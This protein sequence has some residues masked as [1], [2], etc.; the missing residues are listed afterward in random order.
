MTDPIQLSSPQALINRARYAGKDF[1]TF[2]DDLVARVKSNFGTEYDEFVVSALGQMLIDQVAWAAETLSFYVDRQAAESY[3][4]TARTRRAASNIA[5]QLGYKPAR[6]I[7][8]T[9]DVAVNL[10]NVQ[11]VDS[12]INAGFKFQG[13]NGLVFEATQAVT[14][15]AGEGP[16]SVARSISV[17]EGK[18]RTESFVSN[19]KKSQIFPLSPANGMEVLDG[20][21]VTVDAAPWTESEFLTFD[22]ADQYEVDYHESPPIL[23]FGN[24]VAGNIPPLGATI[25][26]EYVESSGAGGLVLSNTIVDVVNTLVVGATSVPITVTNPTPSS[27]GSDAETLEEIKASAPG[28]FASRNVAVTQRDY[29]SLSQAYADPLAGAVAVAQAFVAHGASDD[30]TL[31]GLISDAN[32]IAQAVSDAVAVETSDISSQVTGAVANRASLDTNIINIDARL[33]DIA[34]DPLGTPSGKIV[35][36]RS[37]AA[38]VR[39]QATDIKV[40]A[41]DGI[42]Q[43]PAHGPKDTRFGEIKAAIDALLPALDGISVTAG[44]VAQDV[45]DAKTETSAATVALTSLQASMDAIVVDVANIDLAMATGFVGEV[46]STMTE[47]FDHVDGWLSQDCKANLVQVPILAKDVD[48]FLVAPSNALMRSLEAYL[49]DRREITQVVEVV[50]GAPWLVPASIGGKIGVKDGYVVSVVLADVRKA[51]ED[52]LRGRAFGDSLRLSAVYAAVAPNELTGIGGVSGVSHAVI[53]IVGSDADGNLIV[54]KNQVI[55]RGTITL[56]QDAT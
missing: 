49:N 56:S 14:F 18:T 48:G 44:L 15:P 27:G 12:T 8:A 24:G 20:V 55:S 19:G 50:S 42:A 40:I 6:V 26:V 47:I 29:V 37:A 41:D 32:A 7:S 3:L 5:R 46:S 39:S 34:L 38:T 51:I 11:P 31:L 23:V 33:D 16:A 22:Q 13:P 36:I 17:R 4:S 45:A 25:T 54:T 9:T 21:S 2:V 52:L 35:D 43:T 53:S 28:F 30:L 1:F 10:N